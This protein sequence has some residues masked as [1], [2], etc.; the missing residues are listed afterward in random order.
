LEVPDLLPTEVLRMGE[1]GGKPDDTILTLEEALKRFA[2]NRIENSAETQDAAVQDSNVRFADFSPS[3]KREEEVGIGPEHPP[4]KGVTAALDARK[5]A[6]KSLS[7]VVAMIEGVPGTL[8]DLEQHS[9]VEK[10]F[11]HDFPKSSD[12]PEFPEDESTEPA[13]APKT[14]RITSRTNFA[15]CVTG[16]TLLVWAAMLVAR[17]L[18]VNEPKPFAKAVPTRAL[19]ASIIMRP[20]ELISTW[21]IDPDSDAELSAGQVL[22][23]DEL[24]AAIKNTLRMRAF[25]DI[26]VSVSHWGEAYLAGDVY[27][28]DEARRIQQIA[29]G[30]SGVR[31]V[32]FL[33][34]DVHPAQGP[35]YLGV[36][37]VWAPEVWAAKVHAVS[38][39]SPADKAG[40]QP[41]DVITEFDGKTVP[42]AK[43]FDDLVEQHSPGQR[44]ELRVWH[45]GQPLYILARLGEVT[46]VAS[47]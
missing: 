38:I 1:S 36:T 33:H 11:G 29:S 12:G 14:D 43:A 5:G 32:H 9:V 19:K 16:A 41:G 18:I 27:T 31:R 24:E 37:T 2:R 15:L 4:R 45:D 46:T 10:A 30:V 26:G 28:L 35:A 8:E 22:E 13:T 23:P 47:R 7:N 21:V 17:V 34:P 25:T 3:T 40:I 39:G 44:V 20:Q 6:T 42:D